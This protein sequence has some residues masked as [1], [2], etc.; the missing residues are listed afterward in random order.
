[1]QR[2]GEYNRVISMDGIPGDVRV[3]RSN[4]GKVQPQPLNL[5]YSTILVHL[6]RILVSKRGTCLLRGQGSGVPAWFVLFMVR[7]YRTTSL[8]PFLGLEE[9]Q[10]LD[11]ARL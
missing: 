10:V 9:T 8:V 7:Y 11:D 3:C 4:G 6:P 5:T 1:M 2:N